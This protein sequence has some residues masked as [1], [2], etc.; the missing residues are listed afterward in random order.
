MRVNTQV[1][2]GEGEHTGGLGEGEHT[3]GPGEGEHTGGPGE[4]EHTGG[5][6]E[7]EHTEVRACFILFLKHKFNPVFS[8]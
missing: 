4:G 1:G 3:G 2:W 5:P 8:F 6:G 7:G